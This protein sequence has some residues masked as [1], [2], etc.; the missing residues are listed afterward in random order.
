MHGLSPATL[1][2]EI[3]GSDDSVQLFHKYDELSLQF[4]YQADDPNGPALSSTCAAR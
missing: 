1:D 4:Q 3:F 2:V